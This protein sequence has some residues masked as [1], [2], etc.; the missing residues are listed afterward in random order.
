[1]DIKSKTVVMIFLLLI[2]SCKERPK[3]NERP[4]AKPQET[5]KIE[6]PAAETG[7]T[8]IDSAGITER[9]QGKWKEIEYP[10]RTAQ[11]EGSTVKFVEEGTEAR[12][13]FQKFELLDDCPFDTNNIR[14]LTSGDVILALPETKRCEKLTVSKDTLTLTGFST[15][16]NADYNIVYLK[17]KP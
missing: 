15:N 11:F 17:E 9:L 4:S 7:K 1:M 14:D 8:A 16:T 6:S 12:P 10:Y 5:V 3:E 13:A 2:I